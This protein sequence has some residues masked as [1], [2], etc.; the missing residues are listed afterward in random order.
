MIM[1]DEVKQNM[2]EIDV[3]GEHLR[4][5]FVA[6]LSE[7]ATRPPIYVPADQGFEV[8]CSRYADVMEVFKD[9]ERFSVEPVAKNAG[10]FDRFLGMELSLIHI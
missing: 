1:P 3:A 4:Q 7:W 9:R 5:N 6:I 2:I 8:V 10:Q